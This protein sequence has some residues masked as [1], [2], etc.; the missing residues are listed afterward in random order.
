[1]KSANVEEPTNCKAATS[2]SRLHQNK[3]EIPGCL[4]NVVIVINFVL[5]NR[6]KRIQ[7]IDKS[8]SLLPGCTNECF[9][10]FVIVQTRGQV[11]LF[12]L[13]CNCSL[14]CGRTIKLFP[15]GLYRLRKLHF[16][17]VWI[18]V[19][20]TVRASVYPF[21]I[22][23]PNKGTKIHTLKFIT[24]EKNKSIMTTSAPYRKDV[25]ILTRNKMS[26]R[27]LLCSPQ[28]VD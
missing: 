16:I 14:L 11:W 18:S 2:T 10:N 19:F 13:Y 12:L 26:P 27:N 7:F 21:P 3:L 9:S 5:W 4:K 25:L 6:I 1:M 20:V 8:S 23:S 28:I 15:L 17:F 22:S 24:V